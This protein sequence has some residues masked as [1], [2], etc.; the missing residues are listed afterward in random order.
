MPHLSVREIESIA[1]RV[2]NAYKKL[3]TL[4]GQQISVIQPELLI[5]DML[6]L[7]I[8]YHSLSL[9]GRI[10]GLTSCGKI[11]VPIFDD[12]KHPEYYFLDG[13]TLLIDRS[14]INEGANQ[15][16]RHF[17]IVHE[18]CHQIFRMLFP[19]EYAGHAVRRQ[20]HYCKQPP[21]AADD[22]WEEWRTDSLT[23][24]VL[25]PENMVRNNLETFGLGGRQLMM[26]S[27]RS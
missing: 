12:P 24:A 5:R 14:L 23:S 26:R 8:E 25:M 6:G 13:K 20:I 19:R 15:G 10:L 2:I 3:P 18:G 1:K 7:S 11:G 4:A 27:R 17:T 21:T 16:R 9:D 22:Y